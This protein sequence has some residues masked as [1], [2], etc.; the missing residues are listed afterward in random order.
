MCQK[1]KGCINLVSTCSRVRILP[2]YSEE[3]DEI[4]AEMVF[5]THC[6]FEMCWAPLDKVE[7]I[8]IKKDLSNEEKSLLT[9]AIIFIDMI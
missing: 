5:N 7:I 8:F 9:S 4:I 2:I 1:C 6:F 3:S